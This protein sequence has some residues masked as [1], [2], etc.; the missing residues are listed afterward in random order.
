M[1]LF[2]RIMCRLGRH[3]LADHLLGGRDW[4][5]EKAWKEQVCSVCGIWRRTLGGIDGPIS[6]WQFVSPERPDKWHL[7]PRAARRRAQRTG[8]WRIGH[9]EPWHVRHA[10]LALSLLLG[11]IVLVWLALLAFCALYPIAPLPTGAT[12]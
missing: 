3:S 4:R 2:K 7:S 5:Y 6:T 1:K 8:G 12:P 10:K 11:F 9:R